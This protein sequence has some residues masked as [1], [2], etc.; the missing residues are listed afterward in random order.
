MNTLPWAADS[1]HVGATRRPASPSP[2][3]HINPQPIQ[4]VRGMLD[5]GEG[6]AGGARSK[7][8]PQCREIVCRG[9]KFPRGFRDRIQ[10]PDRRGMIAAIL[11]L[12]EVDGVIFCR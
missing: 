3:Q 1:S 7:K 8:L 2:I 5:L 11:E 9:K 4:I 10:G 12:V 6:K